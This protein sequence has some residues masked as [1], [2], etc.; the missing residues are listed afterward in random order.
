MACLFFQWHGEDVHGL[1]VQD[2]IVS[3]LSGALPQPSVSPASQQGPRFLELTVCVCVPV[4]ILDPLCLSFCFPTTK[5]WPG[6]LAMCSCHAM[7]SYH[8][9]QAKG[10][11]HHWPKL[12]NPWEKRAFLLLSWFISGTSYSSGKLTDTEV[13]RFLFNLKKF[14]FQLS[15]EFGTEKYLLAKCRWVFFFFFSKPSSGNWKKWKELTGVN[16]MRVCVGMY[17][18]FHGSCAKGRGWGKCKVP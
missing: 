15:Q 5:R 16:E 6:L 9:P 17:I 4:A 2:A 11:S 1:G 12:L 18:S 13:K 8:G 7:L 14:S 3:A 10:L